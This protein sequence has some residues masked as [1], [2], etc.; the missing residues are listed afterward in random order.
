MQFIC[1]DRPGRTNSLVVGKGIT[2]KDLR[3]IIPSGVEGGT[4]GNTGKR[5]RENGLRITD[6]GQRLKGNRGN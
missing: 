1:V 3:P 5:R 2:P 4:E 6:K